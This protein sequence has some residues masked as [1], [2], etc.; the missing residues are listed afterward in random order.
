MK[1]YTIVVPASIF[2]LC[3]SYGKG[4][5]IHVDKKSYSNVSLVPGDISKEQF[6]IWSQFPSNLSVKNIPLEY[7]ND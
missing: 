6:L 3:T 2:V 5:F 7:N 1:H 4:K